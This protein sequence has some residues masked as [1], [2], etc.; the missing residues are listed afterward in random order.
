MIDSYSFGKMVVDGTSY[1]KDLIIRP[2]S[3]EPNWWRKEGH[4]LHVEDIRQVIEED[5]PEILVMG[6]GKFGIVKIADETR[7]FLKSK[8]VE[9]IAL[10]TDKAVKIYNELSASGNVVGAF[11]LTC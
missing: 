7:D 1:D 8:N 5:K 10:K 3:V 6:T 9:L 4:A 2:N 11:H